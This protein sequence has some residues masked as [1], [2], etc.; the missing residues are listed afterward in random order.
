MG[1]VDVS[2]YCRDVLGA[3][4][5]I[6]DS[7]DSN[8]WRCR[9]P[10]GTTTD[11]VDLNDVCRNRV[12]SSFEA[13]PTGENGRSWRCAGSVESS[14]ECSVPVGTHDETNQRVN[15]AIDDLVAAVPAEGCATTP[16]YLWFDSVVQELALPDGTGAVFK[17]PSN[18]VLLQPPEWAAYDRVRGLPPEFVGYPQGP[19]E[20]KNGAY[21]LE[22]DPDH[23]SAMVARA[24]TGPFFWMPA[25][26]YLPWIEAGGI[27]SCLG[28]PA[29][30]ANQTQRMQKFENGEMREVV[31][32]STVEVTIDAP[33]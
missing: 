4:I 22:I 3:E 12:G 30:D 29:A 32:G 11:E 16:A 15:T 7:P 17:S 24:R 21:V 1:P 9:N 28:A 27:S 23:R 10:D 6:L 25:A 18:L 8:V 26:T 20:L 13:V 5:G 31:P 2:G 14:A 33:C 19:V